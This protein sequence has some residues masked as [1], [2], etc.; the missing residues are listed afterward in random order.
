MPTS[1]ARLPKP[2]PRGFLRNSPQIIH[3]EAAA[4]APRRLGIV[5]AN[6]LQEP[7]PRF[8]KNLEPT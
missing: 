1:S 6:K 2:L 8:G 7:K 4:F 5:L 3:P